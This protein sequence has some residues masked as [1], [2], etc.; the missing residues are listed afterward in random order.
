MDE[1]PSARMGPPNLP[2]GTPQTMTLPRYLLGHLTIRN[3]RGAAL[4]EYAFLLA[5][6]AMVC[7]LAIGVVGGKTEAKLLMVGSSIN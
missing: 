3:E 7:I 2:R 1:E 5:L 4:V 6:I